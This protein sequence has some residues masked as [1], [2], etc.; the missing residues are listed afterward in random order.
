MGK[1]SILIGCRRHLQRSL[2]PWARS[3]ASADP[4]PMIRSCRL[5]SGSRY[6]CSPSSTWPGAS[7]AGKRSCA[8][9]S[10]GGS[11]LSGGGNDTDW[12]HRGRSGIEVPPENWWPSTGRPSRGCQAH[13]GSS[14]PALALCNQCPVTEAAASR[15]RGSHPDRRPALSADR[16]ARPAGGGPGRQRDGRPAARGRAGGLAARSHLR[17]QG[18][19]TTDLVRTRYG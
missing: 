17:P 11:E 1:R 3:A 14:S 2:G 6:R 18:A 13:G 8:R 4:R 5:A 7:G 19:S 12:D 10:S 16:G 9:R 15:R